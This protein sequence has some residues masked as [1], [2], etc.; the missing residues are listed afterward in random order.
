[1][2]SN[3]QNSSNGYNLKFVDKRRNYRSKRKGKKEKR[4]GKYN[5]RDKKCS[6]LYS[7][8]TADAFPSELMCSLDE[9][10]D[11]R[12]NSHL[13]STFEMSITREIVR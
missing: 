1:M 10:K 12:K 6:G 11:R 5:N 3:H 9:I 8:K 13:L 2:H 7:E 4:V